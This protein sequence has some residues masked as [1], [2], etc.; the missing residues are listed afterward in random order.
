[1]T[2]HPRSIDDWI[3][4]AHKIATDH[5]WWEGTE[6][7]D[8]TADEILARLML[9]VSEIS[10]AAEE[11]RQP[12]FHQDD[13]RLGK[14]G[15]PEGFGVELADAALRLFDLCGRMRISLGFFLERKSAFNETRPK[16]HG[17]RA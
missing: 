6:G 9:V 3:L 17:K 2:T 13:W 5:G 4:H 10:E 12:L 16:R 1:M 14:E 11:V 7:R 8:L 15:K